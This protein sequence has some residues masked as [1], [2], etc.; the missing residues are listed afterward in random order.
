MGGQHQ[1]EPTNLGWRDGCVESTRGTVDLGVSSRICF[2]R[3]P[4]GICLGSLL[5]SESHYL[6]LQGTGCTYLR[7]PLKAK[8]GPQ[9]CRNPESYCPEHYCSNALT[10]ASQALNEDIRA[11]GPIAI[12]ALCVVCAGVIGGHGIRGGYRASSSD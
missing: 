4:F 11:S 10:S 9:D 3:S 1:P 12:C 6:L 7:Q 8:P 2:C 5:L